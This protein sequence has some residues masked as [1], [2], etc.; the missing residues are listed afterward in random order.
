MI[1]AREPI[2]TRGLFEPIVRARR[3]RPIFLI[4]IAVPR[5]VA[6]DVGDLNGVYLYNLDDLQQVVAGTQDGRRDA[7]HA[8]EALVSAAVEDYAAWQRSR[9]MGPIIEQLYQRYHRLAQ[10][11][12]AR[13]LNKLP[14]VSGAERQHLEELARRIVN[15]LLHSPVQALRKSNSLHPSTAQY[16]HAMEKLFELTSDQE[17]P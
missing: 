16:L 5:D 2:I 12:V 4:D 8:A 17:Q 6:A 7:I 9:E 11:E 10:E 3:S 15:K 14:Q 1:Y 13:T